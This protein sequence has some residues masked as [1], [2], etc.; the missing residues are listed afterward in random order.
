MISFSIGHNIFVLNL[1]LTKNGINKNIISIYIDT[2][3]QFN[4]NRSKICK[5]VMKTSPLQSIKTDII[6]AQFNIIVGNFS[7]N[8][9]HEIKLDVRINP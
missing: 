9:F 8:A 3:G 2:C 6:R 1:K 4:S 5:S 7:C